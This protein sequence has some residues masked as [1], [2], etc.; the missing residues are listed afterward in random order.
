M[1]APHRPFE[2]FKLPAMSGAARKSAELGMLTFLTASL[3]GGVGW[4]LYERKVNGNR[5]KIQLDGDKKA[6]GIEDWL[7]LPATIKDQLPNITPAD[8]LFGTRKQE[9]DAVEGEQKS[10][11]PHVSQQLPVDSDSDKE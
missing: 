1:E 10:T 9:K 11:Q 4:V 2:I 3:A 5:V 7:S 8:I 6:G